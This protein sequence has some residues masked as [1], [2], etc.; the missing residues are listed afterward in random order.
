MIVAWHEVPGKGKKKE[1]VPEGQCDCF[2]GGFRATHNPG[3][4][5]HG[6]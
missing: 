4:K 3:L 1:P 6:R 5:P 2:Q